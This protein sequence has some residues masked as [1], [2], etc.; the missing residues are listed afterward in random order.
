MTNY[1][2]SMMRILRRTWSVL[3]HAPTS[4]ELLADFSGMVG[5]DIGRQAIARALETVLG[6]YLKRTIVVVPV[7]RL[8]TEGDEDL[9]E[10]GTWKL[11]RRMI[12]ANLRGWRFEADSRLTELFGGEASAAA[13]RI[14]VLVPILSADGSCLAT[15]V[16]GRKRFSPLANWECALI[17]AAV[18]MATLLL[19]QVRLRE[20]LHFAEADA[21]VVKHIVATRRRDVTQS[22]N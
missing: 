8:C 19:E 12:A 11:G 1:G 20:M 14:S 9:R 21:R 22:N 6:R 3:F 13:K 2:R 18:G 10:D 17:V 4:S 15:V 5:R 7:D 16:I